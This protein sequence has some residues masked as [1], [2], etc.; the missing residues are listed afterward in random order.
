MHEAWNYV[1]YTQRK[2][3]N[4]DEAIKSDPSYAPAYFN[5][6]M[7]YVG[8][9]NYDAALSE[10][11]RAVS[12]NAGDYRA[13]NSR[14]EVNWKFK[15]NLEAALA[16]CEKAVRINDKFA[17]AY[18]NLGQIY[19]ARPSPDGEAEVRNYDSAV[20]SYTR[21]LELSPALTEVY[22]YR[23][24]LFKKRDRTKAEEHFSRDW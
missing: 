14:C 2:L 9:Q 10:F 16:D 15:N 3:G 13:F 12:L 1:G 22:L 8:M 24:E 20:G 4:Y 5:R 17:E 23:G 19:A 11:T 7:A 18:V 21:A 6:G